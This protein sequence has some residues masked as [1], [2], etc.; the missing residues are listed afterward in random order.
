[1]RVLTALFLLL[2]ISFLQAQTTLASLTEQ[3]AGAMKEVIAPKSTYDQSLIADTDKPYLMTFKRVTT[4]DK[5]KS[6]EEK[7]LFNL[8][9]IDP[10]GVRIEAAKDVLRVNL[11]VNRGQKYIQYFRDGALSSYTDVVPIFGL[12]I[13]NGRDIEALFRDAIPLAVPLWEKEA[14][15]AGKSPEQLIQRLISLVDDMSEGGT[16]YRQ[17]LEQLNDYPDRLKLNVVTST[18]KNSK[19]QTS[20]WSLGDLKDSGIRLA[21]SG[22]NASVEAATRD[23]LAWVAVESDGTRQDYAKEV[24]I[25]VPDADRGKL[26]VAVLEKL[27][28]FGEQEIKK[29]LPEPGS[30]AQS[31]ALLSDNL[32]RFPASK[33]E[34]E[35][36][37]LK[38]CQTTLTERQG[39]ATES[40]C[41]FHFGD[42]DPK[43]VKLGMKGEIV[44]IK[45]NTKSKNN[46]VWVS[47]NNAQQ[48][49][50]NEVVFRAGDVEKGR[51]IAHILPTLIEQCPETAEAGDFSKIQQWISK[52][53]APES[54]VTQ[55][56]S[57][58]QSGE[59]CKWKYVE[60]SISEKSTSESTFDFNAYDL[61]PE[62]V[63]IVV[64][65][66]MVSVSVQTVKKQNIISSMVKEKP[67][68]VSALQ[69][70]VADVPA[71]KSL[72]ASL[73]QLIRTCQQQ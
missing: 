3:L 26:I 44:E 52:G 48:N 42:L 11:R 45:V 62:Q 65:K 61:D 71:A 37:I 27:V 32:G 64:S 22:S 34:Y 68:Y 12:G 2:G 67:G 17:R 54:G 60:S 33:T 28:P 36:S 70:E 50:D 16:D 57:L 59:T 29:R 40:L 13:D 18:S 7:W 20:I 46:Y 4:S 1:M 43:S 56:L 14:D 41:G 35:V 19:Q 38:D 69:F 58:Q 53:K 63:K 72:K 9:D 8:A 66:K 49:Y 31:F 55:D 5:G 21:I 73:E 30:A 15:I 51:L 10:K 47:R 25:R 39:A 23:N 24:V 6:F